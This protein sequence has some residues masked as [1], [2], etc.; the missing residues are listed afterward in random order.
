[1]A[2]AREQPHS[3]AVALNDQ[4][5]AAMFDLVDHSG[6]SGTLPRLGTKVE[7]AFL[8]MI[9]RELQAAKT[10]AFRVV[11]SKPPAGGQTEVPN[12]FGRLALRE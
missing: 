3:L 1:M 12:G 7:N 2:V 6:L 5:I 4:A 10:R 9:D 8:S 11:R